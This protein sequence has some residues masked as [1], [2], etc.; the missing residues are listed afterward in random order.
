MEAYTMQ[1]TCVNSWCSDESDDHLKATFTGYIQNFAT[2]A[3][4]LCYSCHSF[5][6]VM[7]LK[8]QR[9]ELHIKDILATLYKVEWCRNTQADLYIDFRIQY[10]RYC[11]CC[12]E[13]RNPK[14]HQLWHYSST[15]NLSWKYVALQGCTLISLNF[16]FLTT[17]NSSD[18]WIPQSQC[19]VG[20]TESPKLGQISMLHHLEL[21]IPH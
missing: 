7:H 10:E 2:C 20:W 4:Y 9:Q 12:H 15:K 19:P 13:R 11:H 21:Q 18:T 6:N 1:I 16:N 5:K 3:V 8:I 14:L 17:C